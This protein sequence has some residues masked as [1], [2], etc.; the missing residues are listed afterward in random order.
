[1]VP[2]VA[3]SGASFKG[4]ALYYLH[5]KQANTNERVAFTVTVNLPT[6]DPDRAV[7]HMIE[8]AE[9]AQELKREAGLKSGRKLQKPVYA[10]S[11]AWH[12]TEAPTK[13]EQIE[14]AK[15]TLAVLGLSN[16]QALIVAHTDREHPHVHVIVNRV[17]PE[18]GRAAVTS[19]D[20]LKLSRWAEA[21]EKVHG[22]V[23]CDA[24]VEN[25]AARSQG[26]W[27]RGEYISREDYYA[28]KKAK[29]DAHWK[30]YREEKG[31][32][33]APRSDQLKALWR[34]RQRRTETRKAETKAMFK[35]IW[36]DVFKRHREELKAFDTGL[37][38]RI[39]TVMDKA[40]RGRVGASLLEAITA[41][42]QLR[43]DLVRQQELE[44][45]QIA[46]HQR[47]YVR[48]ASQEPAQAWKA[49]RDRLSREWKA[50][51]EDRLNRF[52]TESDEIWEREQQSDRKPRPKP[53][54]ER[55]RARKPDDTGRKSAKSSF[56]EH[57]RNSTSSEDADRAGKRIQE[58]TKRSR[59]RPRK[60]GGRKFTPD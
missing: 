28:W 35:P 20:R 44:R 50:Q 36:R 30:R 14:A 2:K 25:N 23:F 41:A 54:P 4:A 51:D 58:R 39:R 43:A 18:T 56:A 26:Q 15:Q 47:Y 49:E 5:D 48:A 37:I 16:R 34:T 55:P 13:A 27:R 6:N 42:K 53:E 17:C 1:M 40:D 19:Q 24:R 3:K 21:Y 46:N 9:L 10:Y 22:K 11:L 57:V 59:S 32:E 29:S 8:T 31:Q 38:G 7:G 45:K 33:N 12:P 60:G 52:K